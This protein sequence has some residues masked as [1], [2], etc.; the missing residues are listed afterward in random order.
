VK[1][2]AAVVVCHSIANMS[3][4]A[5]ESIRAAFSSVPIY[6]CA[7]SFKHAAELKE[8]GADKTIVVS[9]EAGLN[10]GSRLLQDL[11]TPE[12]AIALLRRGIGEALA[13]RTAAELTHPSSSSSS[14]S[15][16]NSTSGLKLPA[17]K[18]PSLSSASS[19][20]SSSAAG[21]GSS[22]SS[23]A[24]D[25]SEAAGCE[26][27]AGSHSNGSAHA[28][29]SAMGSAEESSSSSGGSG[30]GGKAGDRKKRSKK[31]RPEL[32]MFVLDGR[33]VYGLNAPPPLPLA[34]PEGFE[35][36]CTDCPRISAALNGGLEPAPA[37]VQ[38]AAAAAAAAAATASGGSADSSVAETAA[39]GGPKS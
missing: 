1:R 14:S 34:T 29:S 2:P 4:K 31:P 17:L 21:R 25:A 35:G 5:V 36:P 28:M 38:P 15:S 39:P 27:P 9:S 19:S 23:S 8:A 24:S 20:S 32:E 18:L 16:G 11:G 37:A 22:S 30:G 7:T 33:Y 12:S 6:A 3:T 26:A 10:L 13:V